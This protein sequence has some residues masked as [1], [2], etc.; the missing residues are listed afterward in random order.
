MN[1]NFDCAKNLNKLI[2]DINN[3]QHRMKGF[4]PK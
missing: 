4:T 3:S 2:D 1:E